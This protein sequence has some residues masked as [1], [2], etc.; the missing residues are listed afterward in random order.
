MNP[1]LRLFLRLYTLFMKLYPRQFQEEFGEEMATVFSTSLVEAGQKG[2]KAIATVCLQELA[3]LPFSLSQAYAHSWQTLKPQPVQAPGLPWLPAWALLTTVAIP[4]A[5]LLSAPLGAA[6]L[7]ALNPIIGPGTDLP[8]FLD[9]DM[10]RALGFLAALALTMA[11]FQWLLLRP[12]LPHAGWWILVTGLGWLAAGLLFAATITLS[13]GQDL[14]STA[15]LLLAFALLGAAVGLVQWLFLRRVIPGAGWW[16]LVNVIGF[17]S[18]ALAGRSFSSFLE[19]ALLL[20]PGIISGTGLWLLMR[21]APL[22]PSVETR[23]SQRLPQ[24]PLPR[25]LLWVGVVL[26]VLVPLIV[27]GPLVYTKSQLALAKRGGIYA[28]PKEAVIA[29]LNRDWGGAQVVRLEG[30]YVTP[31]WS[32]GRL[33]HVWFGGAN[34]WLDRVPTGYN[35]DNYQSAGSYYIQVEEGWI[36]VPEGAFPG[37]IGRMMELYKLEGAGSAGSE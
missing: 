6:F 34:V 1:F 11:I 31:N 18:I 27:V 4:L 22:S 17:A 12:Y 20:L 24:R 30:L 28:T 5:W 16:V 10:L 3:D 23:S 35:R 14:L 25:R 2:P 33:P 15:G 26:L 7:L 29:H 9:G 13:L 36:H 32:D 21:Q 37:F 19:L 8:S